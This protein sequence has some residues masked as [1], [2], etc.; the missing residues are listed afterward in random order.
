MSS[1]LLIE[2]CCS[3][4]DSFWSQIVCVPVNVYVIPTYKVY[5][6]VSDL[7]FYFNDSLIQYSSSGPIFY[8]KGHFWSSI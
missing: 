4:I 5:I 2:I 6:Q 8:L 7:V 3:K 1:V